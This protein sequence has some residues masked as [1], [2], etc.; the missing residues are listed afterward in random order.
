MGPA[1]GRKVR[2]GLRWRTEDEAPVVLPSAPGYN[3][4]ARVATTVIAAISL[5]LSQSPSFGS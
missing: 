2:S 1:V 5:S 4:L 3:E